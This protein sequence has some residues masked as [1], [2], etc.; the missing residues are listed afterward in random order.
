MLSKWYHNLSLDLLVPQFWNLD[1]WGLE[2]SLVSPDG[3]CYIEVILNASDKFV[4]LR[5]LSTDID[6]ID[7]NGEGCQ[8]ASW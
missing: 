4:T 8:A 2:H 7:T 5:K 1:S 3:F 6:P